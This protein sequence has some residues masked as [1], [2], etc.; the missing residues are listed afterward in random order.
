MGAV[1]KSTD[2]FGSGSDYVN[3]NVYGTAG[4]PGPLG[5]SGA[6]RAEVRVGETAWGALPGGTLSGGG[7]SCLPGAERVAAVCVLGVKRGVA[8]SI[9]QDRD[10]ISV[11][12]RRRC[13]RPDDHWGR[14][15][16]AM[17]NRSRHCRSAPRDHRT[18]VVWI[19]RTRRRAA[20]S[21]VTDGAT[22]RII[23]LSRRLAATDSDPTRPFRG[24]VNVF[25][26]VIAPAPVRAL[27]GVL[28]KVP[29]QPTVP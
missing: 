17:D 26:Y 6:A 7:T 11:D 13:G 27:H 25:V 9:Q 1:D 28:A 12:D 20:R 23:A 14:V 15:G 24:P 19:S 4:R 22:A 18:S 29:A 16:T 3:E 10:E 5:S 21:L 8:G 2:G